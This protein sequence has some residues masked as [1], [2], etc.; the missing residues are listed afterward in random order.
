MSGK[1]PLYARVLRL[2]HIQPG[3][4][5]C[6]LFFEGSVA[7]G[8]LLAL[9]EL[10]PWWSALVLP[11]AVA[12]MVKVNDLVAAYGARARLVPAHTRAQA[13]RRAGSGMPRP[14]V[15]R[16]RPADTPPPANKVRG[17]ATAPGTR[18]AA[19]LAAEL[20]GLQPGPDAPEFRPTATGSIYRHTPDRRDSPQVTAT[21]NDTVG[22]YRRGPNQGRFDWP[23]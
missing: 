20:R 3:G 19:E 18:P 15:P 6:F 7:L 9:A 17:R 13:G 23:N 1:P 2:R 12:L 8:V 11:V 10:A 22:E 14:A 5:L 21:E 16:A 4:L